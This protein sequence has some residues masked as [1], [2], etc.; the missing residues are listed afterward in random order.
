MGYYTFEIEETGRG[1]NCTDTPNSYQIQGIQ[2]NPSE[3]K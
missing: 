1:D 2:C 3:P